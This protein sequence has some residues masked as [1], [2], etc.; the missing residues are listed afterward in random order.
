MLFRVSLD[1]KLYKRDLEAA[2][3]LSLQQSVEKVEEPLTNA[4]GL[5][6]LSFMYS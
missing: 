2:L 5:S 6:I 4:L 1:E 3:S